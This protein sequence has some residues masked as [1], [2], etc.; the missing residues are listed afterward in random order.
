MPTSKSLCVVITIVILSP[1]GHSIM[2]EFSEKN[3]PML[4]ISDT[5]R[6]NNWNKLENPISSEYNLEEPTYKIHSPYGSV[7]PILASLPTGPWQLA[8]LPSQF[9]SRL[10]I[11]QSNSS[12]LASLEDILSNLK[13]EIIDHIPDHSIIISLNSDPSGEIIGQ[14]G[15]LSEVRWIG[16]MPTTWK[17]DTALIPTL[18]SENV[19]LDLDII[20]SPSNSIVDTMSLKLDIYDRFNH[21]YQSSH[22]DE[23]LCQVRNSLPSIIPVL[24]VDHRIL[25]IE[26][27]ERLVIQ[28]SNA[29]IIAGIDYARSITDLNLTG[30]GEVLGITDTGLDEDHG[31]FD[32][33]LRSPIFNLFGP[34]NSGADANSG[35]GTHV[36]ATLLGDG[37][38]DDNATGMVP[39]STFHF[40][41]I[42]VDSSGLLARW[43]SLYEMYEHSFLNDAK[44][45]TNSWGSNSLVGDYTSDSRSVDWFSNDN[46]DLLVIFS[47]GDMG[48]AGVTSPS[49]AKN[50]LSVGAT[51]TAAY[52]SSPI[53]FVYDNSSRG[54][55][56]DGRIK[57]DI[58]APGVM[59]CSARAEEASLA[60][61]SPC[62][63][64]VHEGSSTPLYMTM[65]GSSVSTPVVAGASAMARQYLREELGIMDP[66]SDLI[67]ALLVNGADD[68]GEKNVPNQH[69][70]WGQLN[71][72]NSLFPQKDGDN[73]SLFFDQD[74]QLSPGHSFVYTFDVFDDSGMEATLAWNDKEGSASSNQNAS[75]LVNDLDLV[76]KSPD[77]D[78]YYGNNFGDGISQ[79]GGGRDTLNNLERV[80]IPSPDVGTWTVEVG[81]SGGFVQ[82][83]SLVLAADAEEIQNSD[84]TVVP[85]SIFSPDTSPLSG[86][87]ISLQLSWMN[88]AVSPTG[89]YSILLEDVSEGSQIGTYPMPS[90]GGGEVETFS[91]YHSF[92]STGNHL[93]RLTL[94]HLSEV[95]ELNDEINGG[96]N[97][98]IFELLF[99]VTE[100]GVRIT[101]FLPD[102]SYPSTF[103]EAQSAKMR[104]MD[105][106][107]TTFVNFQLELLNEGTSEITVDLSVTKVQI[108]DE[109][110]I[111][112]NPVDEWSWE[113]NE[114]KP[115][116]LSP[117]GE[118]GDS[119]VISLNLTDEDADIESRY[120]LP[121]LFVTDLTLFD[122]NSPTISH[123]TRLSVNVDRVEGLYTV[124]AGTQGLGAQ[125]D[126]F[127]T[128]FVSVRNIGNGPT[129][130]RVS[131]E[132]EDRWIVWVGGGQASVATIGPLSRLQFVQVPIHV[133][134]P[135][136]S[137]GLSS[138]AEN[139]VTCT[140]TSVN[141]PRL[142]TTETAV[143]EVLE[144]RDFATQIYD[145]AGE[146]IGPLAISDSRAVLNGETVMTTLSISNQGNVPLVF[147]IRALSSSNVWP[148]QIFTEGE[149][150]PNG[151][152]TNME[153]SIG[154]GETTRITVLTVVPLAAE[155]GDKNTV[156]IKTTLNGNTVSNGT[157]LEVK[158]ITTLDIV[159]ESGFSLALGKSGNSDIFLHNSGNVPLI[160]KL[161]IG[162]LPEGWSG[163]L[164]TGDTFSLD[165]NRDSIV[166][167]GLEL[168]S[169]IL[170]G[171]LT[172]KVP[173]IIESTSPSNSKEV[174]TLEIEVIVLPSV[175]IDVQSSTLT[176]QGINENEE[177]E[178]TL[179]ISNLGNMPS[180]VSL[181]YLAP[182]GWT[183][184]IQP[185]EI[186]NLEP[187]ATIECRV[188]VMPRE[189]SEDGLKEL[190]INANS[191]HE[192]DEIA[193]TAS[194]INIDISKTGS[195]SNGGILGLLESA[196]L[197]SWSIGLL[198]IVT[199]SGMI[200]L[201][202]KARDEFA[203]LT[204]QEEIIPRGSAILAG[205]SDERKAAALEIDTTGD[206]VTG[207]VLDSEIEE[208]IQSTVPTLPTHQVPEGA[209]PLPLTGL[210]DGWTM[211]QWVAYGHIWWEQ[212]GP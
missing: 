196:G 102:G 74:R 104:N 73:L 16:E 166:T 175:W 150:P 154:R 162:T 20:P 136:S 168:P 152:V 49:T 68:I 105:P 205:S 24:A 13:I 51:T 127:A 6:D 97:N 108:V 47:V 111:L 113:L 59:I 131:C 171:K 43:G 179:H 62:S 69:E 58:V 178:L 182:E 157:L 130:Y 61:G 88:Q 123:S 42:E 172:E 144:S 72:S 95:E 164:L 79:T 12:D 31:D 36:T 153:S 183:V 78:V 107:S 99:E 82:A 198:F 186:T 29:S 77:G 110:G 57:P 204:P 30:Y 26:L 121:G 98:N 211:D 33:R 187:G 4:T 112:Q 210:P 133:K 90:L 141:D 202:I 207:G 189:S 137:S 140:T 41:Q 191:T 21:Y 134:V 146:E 96:A 84:L 11:V 37:S 184:E 63:L 23:Y 76:I 199:I 208:I 46:P 126:K 34:D 9:D 32:G 8:G 212:N 48:E 17:I 87:T 192:G 115:W 50:V 176:L 143:I 181:G 65:S 125:P 5:I 165:M 80:R 193:K 19:L 109:A 91:I 40:Y 106:S 139:L 27:G 173:V 35:H 75:R 53:G 180:G 124:S 128:F 149:T 70:G 18:H 147:E 190:I 100:I 160:I 151:E 114:S 129:E 135:P 66:R 138:G 118:T 3:S 55:T 86:D 185:I 194:V 195:G 45:H 206:V 92:Q 145:S 117:F 170:P 120:A 119:I 52:S 163:G 56:S 64:N 188:S 116:V 203:P 54:P 209:L 148:I 201:G 94:D 7:D 169:G 38:G 159:S 93:L 197:P 142:K 158:E 67:K 103:E 28:N 177:G 44:I 60:T 85:N 167:I 10:Y 122:K 71:L 155:K 161:T 156:S 132:T 200:F 83:F 101:P 22:C 89:D 15:K 1:L 39:E 174:T 25:R 14:I 81:H 2:S